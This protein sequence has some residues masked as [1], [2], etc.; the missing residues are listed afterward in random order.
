MTINIREK[1][2]IKQVAEVFFSDLWHGLRNDVICRLLARTYNATSVS[3]MLYHGSAKGSTDLLVCSGSFINTDSGDVI[4]GSDDIERV[5]QNI[6]FYEYVEYAKSALDRLSYEEYFKSIKSVLF[7]KKINEDTFYKLKETIKLDYELFRTYKKTFSKETN[8]IELLDS[9]DETIYSPNFSGTQ[10][11]ELVQHINDGGNIEKIKS[12]KLRKSIQKIEGGKLT[13]VFQNFNIVVKHR[14]WLGVPLIANSRCI[15]ILRFLLNEERGNSIKKEFDSIKFISEF[16]SNLFGN[17]YSWDKIHQLSFHD[18]LNLLELENVNFNN[19]CE[20]LRSVINCYGCI[21]R[22]DSEDKKSN[23]IVGY[24]PSV[25]KYIKDISQLGDHLQVNETN[26]NEV[27]DLIFKKKFHSETDVIGIIFNF[28]S[29]NQIDYQSIQ[30]YYLSNKNEVVK[31]TN[32]WHKLRNVDMPDIS[33]VF[34]DDRIRILKMNGIERVIIIKVP[35]LMESYFTFANTT[36]R[37]FTNKDVEVIYPFIRRIGIELSAAQLA[38]KER[39]AKSFETLFDIIDHEIASPFLNLQSGLHFKSDSDPHDGF[40]KELCHQCGFITRFVSNLRIARNILVDNYS[41]DSDNQCTFNLV[42]E[43][44]LIRQ[45]LDI[46]FL[47]KGLQFDIKG[48]K[49]GD[50]LLVK[51]DRNI[52]GFVFYN[53]IDN[54]VKYSLKSN[55]ENIVGQDYI[56]CNIKATDKLLISIENIGLEIMKDEIDSIYDLQYRSS[57][58]INSTIEGSGLGLYFVK[59]CIE[60]LGWNI[61]VTNERIAK[62][63]YKTAFRVEF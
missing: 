12:P 4:I 56:I 46:K 25:G 63:L 3:L 15:G 37:A 6:D 20:A 34:N 38:N 18:E 14:F 30:Y 8:K 28:N 43:L 51:L 44:E 47:E 31:T 11:S 16:I 27:L 36:N 7:S 60:N 22:L 40:L 42:D 41:F 50:P 54:A 39:V 55:E 57:K 10:F 26:A 29:N 1:R 48:I 24:S 19:I 59:K 9:V 2:L 13:W 17:Y 33:K 53:L 45:W 21:F 58:A 32:E 49:S 61:S 52:F 62:N 35:D 23:R 5:L